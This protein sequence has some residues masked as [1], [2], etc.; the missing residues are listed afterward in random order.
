HTPIST[1][2][3]GYQIGTDKET[4]H[5]CD[6]REMHLESTWKFGREMWAGCRNDTPRHGFPVPAGMSVALTMQKLS[7]SI[8]LDTAG[9]MY[10]TTLRQ[11]HI[12]Q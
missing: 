9:C 11:H 6:Q 5:L 10:S 2:S 12:P 3:L 8:F 4:G 7:D 1:I